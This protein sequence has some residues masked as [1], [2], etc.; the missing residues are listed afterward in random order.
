MKPF[1]V[2]EILQRIERDTLEAAR[3]DRDAAWAAAF[4]CEDP[5]GASA[6]CEGREGLYVVG[7][8]RGRR[9]RC[10]IA[11]KTGCQPY[12]RE[13][14]REI[15]DRAIQ[16]QAEQRARKIRR[17]IP[18]RF[19]AASLEG[20]Q[21]PAVQAMRPY[22]D[23]DAPEGLALGLLGSVGCGK[24]WALCGAVDAWPQSALFLE[25]D[26]IARLAGRDHDQ[27]H[28]LTKAAEAVSL[29]ALDD[30]FR[31]YVKAGGLAEAVIEEVLCHRHAAQ[32]ATIIT[33]NLTPE[34]LAKR[35]SPRV[36]DR[37]REWATIITLPAGSLRVQSA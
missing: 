32:M 18:P 1:S 20:E 5:T 8:D 4:T 2:E 36:V 21:T 31:G 28:E 23:V 24:T 15:R 3:P 35:L 12:Q 34:Q 19:M 16:Q 10:P 25:A 27:L 22:L 13:R 29:L 37:L 14:E 9:Q 6:P 7:W 17:G 11:A 33:S 26:T 30:L